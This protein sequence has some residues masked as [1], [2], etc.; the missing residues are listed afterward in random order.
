MKNIL[1]TLIVIGIVG[2]NKTVDPVSYLACEQ[3]YQ[4]DDRIYV[5]TDT[6]NKDV[7][8]QFGN[9]MIE[10]WDMFDISYS[11]VSV[12][13]N[14]VKFN[15]QF[16]AREKKYPDA[17][18]TYKATWDAEVDRYLMTLKIDGKRSSLVEF[19]GE[20]RE[21]PGETYQDILQCKQMD[22]NL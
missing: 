2:C 8:I 10:Q 3:E 4:K 22:K 17:E 1:L 12:T 21:T 15:Y 11:N 5:M 16:L 6:K 7:M 14:L 18:I 19:E 9:S 20:I 13:D